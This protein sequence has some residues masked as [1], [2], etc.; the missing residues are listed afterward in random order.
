MKKYVKEFLFRGMLAAWGGP[1]V[2]AVIYAI[3]GATG[4]VDSLTPMEVAK[5]ILSLTVLAFTAAG[6]TVVYKIEK[7]PLFPAV[8]LH[9]VVLYGDYLLM[10]LVNGWLADGTKPLAIFTGVFVAGYALIWLCIWT[11]TSRGTRMVNRKLQ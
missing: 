5:G 2:L 3:L 1:V 11:V 8:L 10:Y 4:A 7:L 6:I 9:G